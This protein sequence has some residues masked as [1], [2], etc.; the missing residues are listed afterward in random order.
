MNDQLEGQDSGIIRG[1]VRRS[2]SSTVVLRLATLVF[3]GVIIVYLKAILV[4]LVL[5]ALLAF[6]VQPLISRLVA[7]RV[8]HALAIVVGEIVAILPVLGVV[9]VFVGTAGPLTA[10]LPEYQQRLTVQVA[11]VVDSALRQVQ[12]PR[13]RDSVRKQLTEKVVPEMMNQ[14]VA[15]ADTSLRAATTVFGYFFLTLLFSVFMLVEGH[16]L[17]GRF[18]EAYGRENPITRS[19][20]SIGRDV[21]AYVVA[22][23]WISGLTSLCVWLYLELLGVDFALFWGLLAFPLNFIPTVG[24]LLASIPPILVALVDPALS[25]FATLAV[26]VGLLAIN[27]II[28]TVLDPRFVGQAVRLSPLV[29]LLS[30]LVWGILWGPVGMILAVPIMVSFKLVCARIP[31]LSHWATL[32][33]G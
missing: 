25:S 3:A 16:R 33:K 28:G 18:E 17:H 24:A 21:R 1:Q 11:E 10:E 12:D 26:T 13:V 20:R 8:P 22:K 7:R 31:S 19:L 15:L 29:V 32:M 9:F 27:G 14:G 5:A 2:G 4:P 30:M 6:L 23:T